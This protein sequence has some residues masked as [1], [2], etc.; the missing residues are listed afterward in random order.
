M[1]K[2]IK[3][4]KNDIVRNLNGN[5]EVNFKPVLENYKQDV[6]DIDQKV[7][8]LAELIIEIKG[9]NEEQFS[10]ITDTNKNIIGSIEEILNT[11]DDIKIDGD[12]GKIQVYRIEKSIENIEKEYKDY[13]GQVIKIVRKVEKEYKDNIEKE[14]QKVS[15]TT[16]NN[17]DKIKIEILE[18]KKKINIT[19]VN[20]NIVAST[21]KVMLN[22][23]EIG[24]YIQRINF[25]GSNINLSLTNQ[26]T[27]NVSIIGGGVVATAKQDMFQNIS[28]NTFTLSFIPSNKQSIRI[29]LYYDNGLGTSYSPLKTTLTGNVITTNEII[30]L[31]NNDLLVISYTT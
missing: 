4:L 15:D 21:L 24:A 9:F 27:L 3:V 26:N 25:I 22:S 29:D 18:L 7:R 2:K 10:T 6:S 31:I 30:T 20:G 13:V 5:F 8:E 16:N 19:K 11:I 28:T 17:F 14:I 1:K 12:D 23:Q